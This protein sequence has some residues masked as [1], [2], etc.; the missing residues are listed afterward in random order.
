MWMT[1]LTYDFLNSQNA[2]IFEQKNII[3]VKLCRFVLNSK[4][5]QSSTEYLSQIHRFTKAILINAAT[6]ISCLQ[7]AKTSGWVG[8]YQ[9][10]WDLLYPQDFT[11]IHDNILGEGCRF[12]LTGFGFDGAM[13]KLNRLASTKL[14]SLKRSQN[15]NILTPNEKIAYVYTEI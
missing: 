2:L 11:A 8:T 7:L 6:N 13:K 1:N 15:R 14:F 3:F 12:V 10:F 9:R 5:A 4:M